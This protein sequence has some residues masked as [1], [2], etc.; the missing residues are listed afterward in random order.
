MNNKGLHLKYF[1]LN[2]SKS[3][4]HGLASRMAMIT[5]ANHIRY[6]NPELAK[7]LIEWANSARKTIKPENSLTTPDYR[8]GGEG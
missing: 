5:Y 2:P 7:D 3:N 6:E 8:I 1:V 4:K